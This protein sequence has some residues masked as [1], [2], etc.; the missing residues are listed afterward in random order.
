MRSVCRKCVHEFRRNTIHFLCFRRKLHIHSKLILRIGTRRVNSLRWQVSSYKIPTLWNPLN[1]MSREV[2][3]GEGVMEYSLPDSLV[4]NIW[5]V[6]LMSKVRGQSWTFG[7]G[8]TID[9]SSRNRD[10]KVMQWWRVSE[11]LSFA[12]W[13]K[14]GGTRWLVKIKWMVMLHWHSGSVMCPYW[15]D[16]MCG[17]AKLSLLPVSSGIS[18]F[19]VLIKLLLHLS[20]RA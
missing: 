12:L 1:R 14:F 4:S 8:I 9:V 7:V 13:W 5:T 17:L 20:N 19:S 18:M 3:Y 10:T 15:S 6:R 11:Q 16:S 2:G